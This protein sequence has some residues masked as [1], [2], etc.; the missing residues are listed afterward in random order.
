MLGGYAC[1]VLAIVGKDY[2]V[3]RGYADIVSKSR[4]VAN[5]WKEDKQWK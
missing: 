2:V 5:G 1:K 3:Y 4:Y